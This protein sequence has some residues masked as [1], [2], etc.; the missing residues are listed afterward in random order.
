MPFKTS[1]KVEIGARSQ[2]NME[3]EMDKS[4]ARVGLNTA[5]LLG[6]LSLNTSDLTDE[7]F[8]RP[9]GKR[10]PVFEL[11][12]SATLVANE[13]QIEQIDDFIFSMSMCSLKPQRKAFSGRIYNQKLSGRNW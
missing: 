1:R 2:I 6:Q 11:P 3:I 5:T 8:Y 4:M 7:S 9:T 12:M 13:C 10:G